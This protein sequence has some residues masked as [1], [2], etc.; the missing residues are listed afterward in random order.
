V[1]TKVIVDP[2]TG[3]AEWITPE[4]RLAKR[5]KKMVL[6]QLWHMSGGKSEWRDVPVVE[7]ET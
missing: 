3:K 5:G 7:D 6:Q 1:S 4:I 2:A